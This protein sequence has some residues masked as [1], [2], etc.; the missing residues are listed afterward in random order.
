MAAQARDQ[1][2]SADFVVIGGGASGCAAA[3]RL[4][5]LTS[6]RVT[7][8]EAGATNLRPEVID[9]T[10]WPELLVTDAVWQHLTVPQT[11]ANGRQVNLTMGR[12]LGGS[13]SVNGM[14]YMRGA[15]WDYSRWES[16]GAHG[17]GLDSVLRTYRD[18]ETFD[19]PNADPRYRG[20]CGPVHVAKIETDHPLTLAFAEACSELGYSRSADFN[21]PHPEGYG[22]NQL[23]VWEGRR[24]D[25]ASVFLC[26]ASVDVRLGCHVEQLVLDSAEECVEE[27]VYRSGGQRNRIGVEGEVLLAAGAIGSPTLLLRSG[28][29]PAE[30]L[31]SCGI[32]VAVEAPEVGRNFHDHVGVP[33]V[34]ASR[35]PVPP[36]RFQSTEA[37]LYLRVATDR[38]FDAQV[39]MQLFPAALPSEYA[40]PKDAFCFFPGILKPRSRG[41][42]RLDPHAPHRKELIDPNYLCEFADLEALVDVIEKVQALQETR[43]LREWIEGPVAPRSVRGSRESLREYVKAMCTTYY[44]PVGSCRMGSDRNSVTDPTLRVR[45]IQNLR[46]VDASVMPEIVSGNTNAPAMMIGWRGG[47]FAA[48]SPSAARAG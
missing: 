10:R 48:G 15:P 28:I 13:S 25:A 29:G 1:S 45:G 5:A 8:L 6:S 27:V 3:G 39:S 44:H 43:A 46:V 7:L 38:A 4:A 42:V 11:H 26:D 34:C 30:H 17:W 31:H 40:V 32:K 47:E 41:T 12:L 16:M 9:P 14:K 33:I 35:F 18:I 36:S 22:F 23:N 37:T 24:Q 19:S 21:G 20:R 2:E